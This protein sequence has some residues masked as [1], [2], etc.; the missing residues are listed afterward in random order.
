MANFYV[1]YVE[2]LN[3][4]NQNP[5]LNIISITNWDAALTAT[6]STVTYAMEYVA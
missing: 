1:F 6:K 2:N 3:I 5:W 4:P